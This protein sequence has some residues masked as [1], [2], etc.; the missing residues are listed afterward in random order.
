MHADILV[1][2]FKAIIK[3][4][5]ILLNPLPTPTTTISS[6]SATSANPPTNDDAPSPRK[7]TFSEPLATPTSDGPIDQ[8]E[9]H[10]IQVRRTRA[11]ILHDALSSPS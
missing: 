9:M 10:R 1:F 8:A 4:C 3:G 6:D 11:K 7:V 5:Q 2:E